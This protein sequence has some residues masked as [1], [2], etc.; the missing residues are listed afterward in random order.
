MMNILVVNAGSSSLKYQLFD[1]END[2]V[3][4]RGLFER[5][6]IDGRVKHKAEGHADYVA[7]IPLPDHA[8]AVR[9]LLDLLTDKEH[10]ALKSVSDITAVGHRVVH[11]G[12]KFSSSAL[13]TG[14]VLAAIESVVPL[15]PLHNPP[16]LVGISACREVLGES[17]PHV[18]VFD[19]AFHQS[20]P[21]RAFLYAVPYEYYTEN[22][23]RR[24]GFHGTS[25]RYV[26]GRAAQML[27]KPVS[28]LK[29]VTCHL[30]NG[31]SIAAV[32]GGRSADTSM[33][34]T[35]LEGV[36]MGTRSGSIDPAIIAYLCSARGMTVD[37]V[38]DALNKKSGMLGVSGVSP[39]FRDLYAAAADGNDR[40]Q[41]ALDMFAYSVRKQ[42]G[43]LAAAM[44]GID[45]LVFTAGVGENNSTMRASVCEG[46]EF[47][48]VSVDGE[49]NRAA[50]G[51]ADISAAGAR[52]RVLV[53]PTDE[54]LVIARDT[55]DLI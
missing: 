31:S 16:N 8:A 12:E 29:I 17:I 38:T 37:Q 14:D 49:K 22:Q 18:A 47:M 52:V 43:A 45:V 25:H 11:G 42:T 48:G 28:E 10:G 7:D 6:G 27:G 26:S 34:M 24:Y 3:P 46:L 23:V 20:M 41:L 35:P 50:R 19:T 21:K 33:G 15:A 30:G 36:P 40:A 5:I 2:T 32:D 1:M 13:V 44:G 53:V 55:R 54:E 4:A 9:A 51:E 39:D